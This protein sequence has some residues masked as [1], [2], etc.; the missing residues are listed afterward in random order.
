ML[1]FRLSQL[2]SFG[3][4]EGDSSDNLD[5]KSLIQDTSKAFMEASQRA[6]KEKARTKNKGFI[7]DVCMKE[8][9]TEVNM[10][11]NEWKAIASNPKLKTNATKNPNF[12]FKNL[13]R[14]GVDVDLGINTSV[15][16]S[17][18]LPGYIAARK[19]CCKLT[20]N[21]S[22]TVGKFL[23]TFKQDCDSDFQTQND[24]LESFFSDSNIAKVM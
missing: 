5:A 19:S 16:I 17:S 10:T 22:A 21:P 2:V 11:L 12:L 4:V 1:I 6:E 20:S 7:D 15:L 24:R 8:Y 13:I 23:N 9:A 14:F 18:V 3:F